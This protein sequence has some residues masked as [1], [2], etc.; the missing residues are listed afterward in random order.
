MIEK[1]AFW[2]LLLLPV[3]VVAANLTITTDSTTRLGEKLGV[4]FQMQNTTENETL[5]ATVCTFFTTDND[6]SMLD[7]KTYAPQEPDTWALKTNQG[8]KA[9]YLL[10]ITDI[11]SVD[12][13]YKV[14]GFC[15]STQANATFTVLSG[16][17][18]TGI[19]NQL[20]WFSNN[21][22][23]LIGLLIVGVIIVFALAYSRGWLQ[24]YF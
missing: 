16:S 18:N 12:T 5:N 6:V 20:L 13:G 22:E 7:L 15:G 14:M 24:A 23:F 8:G 17:G 10:S 11:Y 9:F 4:H 2:I 3:L 19:I 21:S 1:K